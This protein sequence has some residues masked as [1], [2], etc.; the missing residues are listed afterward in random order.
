MLSYTGS[1]KPESQEKGNTHRGP[2]WVKADTLLTV[3]ECRP[4][5]HQAVCAGTKD[6]EAGSCTT[7]LDT[8]QMHGIVVAGGRRWA[9]AAHCSPAQ[10]PVYAAASSPSLATS[11][12]LRFASLA[13]SL[14]GICSMRAHVV[15]MANGKLEGKLLAWRN[16]FLTHCS[17]SLGGCTAPAAHRSLLRGAWF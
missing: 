12:V 15:G 9:G 10:L 6:L 3:F 4:V 5:L 11:T 7:R 17:N 2:D 16:P 13:S 8:W 1:W 14:A